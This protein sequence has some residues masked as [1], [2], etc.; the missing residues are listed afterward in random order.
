VHDQEKLWNAFEA[1][2]RCKDAQLSRKVNI[3][4]PRELKPE[5]ARAREKEA[6]RVRMLEQNCWRGCKIVCV[7][8]H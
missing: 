2:E 5:E 1:A 6:E 8:G 4:L 3:A 7:N